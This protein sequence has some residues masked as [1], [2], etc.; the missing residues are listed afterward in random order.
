[1]GECGAACGGGVTRIAAK[2]AVITGGGSGVGLG[3][4]KALIKAGPPESDF[5]LRKLR[6]ALAIVVGTFFGSTVL[7]FSAQGL[8][9]MPMTGEFHWSRFQFS[10]GLSAMMLGGMFTAPLMGRL[11]DK[12]GVRRVVIPGVICVGLMTMALS[13]LN[14][15]FWHYF[16][17]YM[18]LGGL[19]SSAVGYAKVLGALFN[20]HR[21]KAM[22]LF[23]MESS[24]SA[25]VAIAIIRW[26]MEGY[27]W[28]GTF[29]G[30]GLIILA[31]VPVLWLFLN[32]PEPPKVDAQSTTAAAPD[33]P[34]MTVKQAL[35]D[36][37]FWTI[38]L[39]T[40]FAIIPAMG[41]MQHMIPFMMGK[42]VSM[43]RGAGTLQVMML[44]M[45]G[46]TLVGGFLLDPSKSGKVA[47]P[48]AL[49]STVSIAALMFL[50][51]TPMGMTILYAAVGLMGFAAGA[52]LPM[53]NFMQLRYFGLR[54]FGGLAG[55][56][57]PFT[58]AGMLVA[59]PAMG[60]C[61]DHF[62]NYDLAMWIMIGL[63]G[64]TVPLYA[65]LGPYRYARD[66]TEIEPL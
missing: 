9:L 46:G 45:A 56:Q 47:A 30:M 31:T 41:L 53:A 36:R 38:T 16:A 64:L 26:L 28:R 60:W 6:V 21:G 65:S 54:E 57:A 44:M 58:A 66:L 11:V 20:E 34:G 55:L 5:S 13:Q 4:A 12:L 35:G 52:K 29:T 39:A 40:F 23:G 3:Q 10:L 17:A 51:G 15:T 2:T 61:F 14:G 33:V 49:L 43:E 62:G 1:V 42:G 8:L 37:Y 48:F 32:E 24:L 22:A 27:G 25:F 59:P 7:P 19:G 63:V 50:S 18:I